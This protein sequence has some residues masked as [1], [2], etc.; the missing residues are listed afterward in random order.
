MHHALRD[1][2][3]RAFVFGD[4]LF[5][6]DLP[7]SPTLYSPLEVRGTCFYNRVMRSWPDTQTKQLRFARAIIAAGK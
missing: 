6:R 5:V 4:G 2:P 7:I 3:L 1:D